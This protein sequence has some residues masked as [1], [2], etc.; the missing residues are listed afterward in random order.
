MSVLELQTAMIAKFGEEDSGFRQIMN[1]ITGVGVCTLAIGA[2]VFMIG[3]SK[4]TCGKR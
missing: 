2:G 1:T 3:K 4:A